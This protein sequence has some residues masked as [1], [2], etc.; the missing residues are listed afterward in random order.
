MESTDQKSNVESKCFNTAKKSMDSLKF[1]KKSKNYL[2]CYC[3]TDK[4]KET[5]REK[6]QD[7][8]TCAQEMAGKLSRECK[9]DTRISQETKM[10]KSHLLRK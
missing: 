7:I 2:C 5:S 3:F 4:I 1:Y 6:L 8:C 9:S 10:Q